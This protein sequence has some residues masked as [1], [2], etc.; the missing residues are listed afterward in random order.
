VLV[1]L[2]LMILFGLFLFERFYFS[3]GQKEFND[4]TVAWLQDLYLST[5]FP[6]EPMADHPIVI[7][8]H[9]GSA[10]PGQIMSNG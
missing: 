8:G 3:C 5:A 10:V 1:A 6:V 7:S 9:R 2:S 4:E